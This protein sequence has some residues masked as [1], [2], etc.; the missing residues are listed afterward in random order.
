MTENPLLEALV[1][2]VA[3]FKNISL[4][5]QAIRTAYALGRFDMSLEIAKN[6]ILGEKKILPE[7]RRLPN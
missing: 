2:L 5:R 7:S 3:Q 4:T 6:E 1:G